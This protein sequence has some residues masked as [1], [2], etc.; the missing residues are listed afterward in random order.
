MNPS[1]RDA[2]LIREELRAKYERKGSLTH[3]RILPKSTADVHAA[4]A[5][6]SLRREA[7]YHDRSEITKALGSIAH[8][9]KTNNNEVDYNNRE[10]GNGNYQTRDDIDIVASDS[11][12]SSDYSSDDSS[13]ENDEMVPT[14]TRLNIAAYIDSLKNGPKTSSH[15]SIKQSTTDEKNK[16]VPETEDERHVENHVSI[17]DVNDPVG[18]K[19]S[20]DKN[21]T[22]NDMILVESTTQKEQNRSFDD[23]GLEEHVR[24]ASLLAEDVD[25]SVDD[26]NSIILFA[27]EKGYPTRLLLDAF[28]E[29]RVEIGYD[30][31][32]DDV[33]IYCELIRKA[34][35]VVELGHHN[36]RNTVKS[37]LS[38]VKTNN[39]DDSLIKIIID[40]PEIHIRDPGNDSTRLSSEYYD[41]FGLQED[42]FDALSTSS[43]KIGYL[44]RKINHLSNADRCSKLGI[45]DKVPQMSAVLLA[46][47][48]RKHKALKSLPCLVDFKPR[49]FQ[50]T[51]NEKLQLHPGFTNVDSITETVLS[52]PFFDKENLVPVSYDDYFDWE[53][54]PIS[55]FTN[56]KS[57]TE[58]NWF[59]KLF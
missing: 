18:G 30:P 15:E 38:N 5:A 2:D 25:C 35:D 45:T 40:H 23:S 6:I 39:F 58:S 41:E 11:D 7:E 9:M 10:S 43:E 37:L 26:I 20:D 21:A 52:Q 44:D 50:S 13:V 54:V 19:S 51:I 29:T 24:K 42:S 32:R 12:I 56:R 14:A 31:R 16:V 55:L 48:V 57:V 36:F 1:F 47:K 8:M 3:S 53:D 34:I 49:S 33:A 59:G 4:I 22:I 28:C 17:I 27:R 46:R